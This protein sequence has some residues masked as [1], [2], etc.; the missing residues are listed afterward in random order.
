MF[1]QSLKGH[2]GWG[3]VYGMRYM[4]KSLGL[5]AKFYNLFNCLCIYKI[6]LLNKG[7]S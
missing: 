6:F 4:G 7:V 1:T 3:E 5:E 2:S